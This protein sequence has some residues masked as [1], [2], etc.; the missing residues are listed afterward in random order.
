MNP[1][2]PNTA[3]NVPQVTPV[4]T[5][6][7]RAVIN[8]QVQIL[9]YTIH[10]GDLGAPRPPGQPPRTLSKE[11]KRYLINQL[12]TNIAHNPTAHD[13]WACD[14]DS[15]VISAGAL[16]N[17][18]H[19]TNTSATKLYERTQHQGANGGNPTMM[20][21]EATVTCEGLVD[22][23]GLNMY[24]TSQQWHWIPSHVTETLNAMNIISWKQVYD[25][26]FRGGIA[27]RRFYPRNG[28]C[29]DEA[30][31]MRNGEVFLIRRGYSTSMRP[32]AGSV[33]L[34]V[35]TCASAFYSPMLLSDWIQHKWGGRR[36]GLVEFQRQFKNVRVKVDSL[37][38]LSRTWRIFGIAPGDISTVT[39]IDSSGTQQ[40]V[41]QY[42]P[43]RKCNK[44]FHTY[45]HYLLFNLIYLEYGG[46]IRMTDHGI[47]VGSGTRQIWFAA[48]TVEDGD[49]RRMIRFGEKRTHANKTLI[50]A[51]TQNELQFGGGFYNNFG[52][53]IFPNFVTLNATQLEL[54]VVMYSHNQ[55]PPIRVTRASWNLADPKNKNA[56]PIP[57]LR[58]A[59]SQAYIGI[60]ILNGQ[61]INRQLG[62]TLVTALRQYGVIA[63]GNAH[64]LRY[65]DVIL[66]TNAG[67][68]T[69]RTGCQNSL[70]AAYNTIRTYNIG[71]ILVVLPQPLPFGISR[72]DYY[73]EVKRWG[74]C[75]VGVPTICLQGNNWD[76]TSRPEFRAN[77]SLK[78]NFK[79]GGE[80]HGIKGSQGQVGG[81]DG[82][83]GSP[84][85]T[86][87]FG[88]DVTHPGT[89]SEATCPSLAAVVATD[90]HGSSNYLAS[91]RVQETRQ[92]RIEDLRSMVQ[93]RI[94]AWVDRANDDPRIQDAYVLPKM[95]LFYRDGVSESQYDMVRDQEVPEIRA[96][97]TSALAHLKAANQ[98]LYVKLMGNQT[99]A[100][101]RYALVVV[102]AAKRHNT[103]FYPVTTTAGNNVNLTAGKAFEQSILPPTYESF[104]LQSHRSRLGTA[105]S[106]YYVVIT[107]VD[108]QNSPVGLPIPRLQE[109]TNKLC[110]TSSR[111]TNGISIATPA[112]YADYVCDRLCLY[113]RP[114]MVRKFRFAFPLPA[115]A[116]A[117]QPTPMEYANDTR[118]WRNNQATGPNDNPWRSNLKNVMF[119]I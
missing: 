58:G 76:L 35:H 12:L 74:D 18:C 82:L 95:L 24:L 30:Q 60:F 119:Y 104:F 101:F 80:N 78:F 107:N 98:A 34:N 41:Q 26:T 79:L 1:Q 93:E 32:G 53:R 83:A 25:P 67:T 71:V 92:E 86:M 27:G 14:Y 110:Y 8:P 15:I 19:L 44:T 96:G 10:L 68:N 64:I 85:H 29:E 118:L 91:G 6:H 47:N 31:A 63:P 11:T 46:V 97:C 17:D 39:F 77:L 66:P 94:L 115:A 103:R 113:T 87:I 37:G 106:S 49:R 9:K 45:V 114:A 52:L 72:Q 100:D 28:N 109:I 111:T 70:R 57:L 36:S 81:G 51:A 50:L 55:D 89:Q 2:L 105:R 90:G 73:A 4:Y 84:D 65:Q 16:Y 38:N 88:A 62:P 75:E 42:L 13:N 5:N 21:E 48:E 69:F 40:N 56:P 99:P 116:V 54:P 20:I 22:I 112:R 102:V 33:Y 23:A 61:N 3:T 108:R 43:T 7:F 59:G 117:N